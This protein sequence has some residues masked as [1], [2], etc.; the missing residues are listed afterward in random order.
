MYVC[1]SIIIVFVV[2]SDYYYKCRFFVDF[3]LVL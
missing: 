2:P 1:R 3:V